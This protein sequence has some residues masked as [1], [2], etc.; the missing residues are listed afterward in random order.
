MRDENVTDEGL[1]A[2]RLDLATDSL[3]F[4]SIRD[5]G[6]D[7]QRE[8]IRRGYDSV[9]QLAIDELGQ[10]C[11]ELLARVCTLELEAAQ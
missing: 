8:A 7:D 11:H 10:F 6:A 1:R 2:E 4:R 9:E 5:R 3:R